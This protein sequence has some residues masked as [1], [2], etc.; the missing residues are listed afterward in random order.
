MQN[1]FID[2]AN[3]EAI[4]SIW[5][6]IYSEGLSDRL[7]GITTNPKALAK[8]FQK[9]FTLNDLKNHLKALNDLMLE[10][11][12]QNSII[13]IQI[14]NDKFDLNVLEQR[15]IFVHS[16]DFK[17]GI[18]IPHYT[19]FLEKLQFIRGVS[20]NVTGVAD[21]S[22]AAKVLSWE[23]LDYVSIIPGRMEE[24][25]IDYHT[26]LNILRQNNNFFNSDGRSRVIAGSMRTLS[27]LEIVLQYNC[28]PTLGESAFNSIIPELKEKDKSFLSILSKDVILRW[29]NYDKCNEN[30]TELSK[31][32]FE[33]MNSVNLLKL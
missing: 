13:Y 3:P 24:K 20:F 21:F 10:F 6:Q 8:Y 2:T 31:A 5:S 30:G 23:Y 14:P 19:E 25:G 11:G 4:K 9:E 32:F 12:T 15:F 28:V 33:E 22:V 7:E 29:E 18:K 16:L 27:Q 26:G 1:F 17:V